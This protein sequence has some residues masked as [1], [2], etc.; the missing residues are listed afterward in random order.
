[1]LAA[2]LLHGQPVAGKYRGLASRFRK[3]GDSVLQLLAS[4]A[5]AIGVWMLGGLLASRR[6]SLP[7]RSRI[8]PHSI[9]GFLAAGLRRSSLRA[10]H[11]SAASSSQLST[12][13]S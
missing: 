3:R 13:N 4:G 2:A 8:P 9:R 7:A 1:V 10:R 11:R 12:V 5:F 6:V